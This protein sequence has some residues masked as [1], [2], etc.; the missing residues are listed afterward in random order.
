M[1]FLFGCGTLLG[2]GSA[3]VVEAG[4]VVVAVVGC[5]WLVAACEWFGWRSVGGLFR[6]IVYRRSPVLVAT[7]AGGIDTV[8]F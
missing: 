5:V 7:A 4:V 3:R 8:P 2:S 1:G 6:L